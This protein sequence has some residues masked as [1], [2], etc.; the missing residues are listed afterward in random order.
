MTEQNEEIDEAVFQK[1]IAQ[2]RALMESNVLSSI[3]WAS[4]LRGLG[5]A[6]NS[7][8]CATGNAKTF[9]CECDG[10]NVTIRMK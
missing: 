9:K 4:R 3:K 6:L 5:V 2:C 8:D 7:K 10:F 1:Y